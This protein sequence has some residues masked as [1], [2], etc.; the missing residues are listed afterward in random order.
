MLI[1]VPTSNLDT[2]LIHIGSRI[3]QGKNVG[4]I[5]CLLARS[6]YFRATLNF[7]FSLENNKPGGTEVTM[8]IIRIEKRQRET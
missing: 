4:E 5:F 1:E 8:I 2:Q 6:L 3:E 7:V